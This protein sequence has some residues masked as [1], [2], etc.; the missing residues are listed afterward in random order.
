[1]EPSQLL[2][3]NASVI[4][5]TGAK[6]RKASVLVVGDTIKAVGKAADAAAAPTAQRLDASGLTLMPGIIDGHVHS[7]FD[8]A[9]GHDELFYH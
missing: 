9:A 3:Q 5:G 6:P 4:D 1:M 8:D 7:T 2:I